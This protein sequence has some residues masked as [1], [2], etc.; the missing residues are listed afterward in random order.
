MTH[1]HFALH[2]D[3]PFATLPVLYWNDEEIGQTLTITRFLARKLGLAGND[4]VEM[5]RADCI[6]EQVAGLMNSEKGP[7]DPTGRSVGLISV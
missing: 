5:A 1:V 7:Q 6:A 3:M 4:D 2:P